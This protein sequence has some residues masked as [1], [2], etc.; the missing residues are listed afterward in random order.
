MALTNIPAFPPRSDPGF[1]AYVDNFF[2]SVLPLFVSELDA[3]VI[4]FNNGS[5]YTTSST[6]QALSSTTPRTFTVGAGLSFVKGMWV[7]ITENTGGTTSNNQFIARVQSYSGTTLVVDI[8]SF[9]GTGTIANWLI[10]IAPPVNNS[11]VK[12]EVRLETGAGY[13]TTNTFI[14]NF[15]S[16]SVNSGTALTGAVSATLG[17]SITVNV[18]G[19]YSITYQEG[20]NSGITMFVSKNQAV[21]T[22]QPTTAERIISVGSGAQIGSRIMEL[23]AGD[24]IRPSA[25]GTGL[26]A[27]TGC[28]FS[29]V[30][31][32]P[33]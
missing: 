12:S 19:I 1:S 27:T 22:A 20:S 24:V 14:R 9:S 2:T 4:G 28:F 17:A 11:V 32:Q 31:L 15:S 10:A 8:V 26:S 5:F 16:I 18:T 30:K 7:T 25:S 6:S 21:L 33:G 3:S 23:T 13:G 29:I